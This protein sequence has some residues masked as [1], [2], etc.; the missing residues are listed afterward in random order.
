M[1][2][3]FLTGLIFF[4]KVECPFLEMIK[5][6]EINSRVFFGGGK[7]IRTL[8]GVSPNGFQEL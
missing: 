3:T 6:H 8:V 5:A 4:F 7:G 1:M 2:I